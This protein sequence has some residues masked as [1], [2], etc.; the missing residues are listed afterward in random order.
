MTPYWLALT[1]AIVIS[2]AGQVLL[3]SGA[4]AADLVSQVLAFRTLLG[5]ALYGGAA[6]LY[7]Y[8]L[9]RIAMSVALPCTAASYVAALLIGHFHFNEPIGATHIAAIGLIC[10]GVVLLAVA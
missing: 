3:K 9:R 2:L 5:L 4:G 1:G 6:L 7:I 8:A 10:A